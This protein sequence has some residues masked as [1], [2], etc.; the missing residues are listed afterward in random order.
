RSDDE[1][2]ERF[3]QPL[4]S[5]SRSGAKISRDKFDDAVTLYYSMMGWNVETG[6]PTGKKLEELGLNW[7]ASQV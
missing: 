5:G 3:F 7:L 6:V 2:P 4:V 1:L